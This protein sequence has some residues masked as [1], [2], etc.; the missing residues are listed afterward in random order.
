MPP[1][2]PPLPLHHQIIKVARDEDFRSRIGNDGRY[3]DLVDFSAIDV[4]YVPNSLTI[5]E[6][7]IP[8]RFNLSQG[9]L[10]EKFGTPVQC[11]HLWWWARRLNKTYRV[12]R[13][14]TTEEEKLSVCSKK[15]SFHFGL[16]S[17]VLSKKSEK[18][19]CS[20]LIPNHSGINEDDAL[21]TT[22]DIICY[23]KSL[24]QNWRIY[25]SVASFLQ[26]VCDH[27]EEEWKRHILEEEIAVLKRQADT[28]RLQKDESM[29]V[30]DQLKH[31]RDN[32]VRQ[33]NELCD[34]STP[35]IL[36]FSRKDLEQAIEHFKNTGDFGDTE[37]GHLYKGMIH[38]TIVAIKLSSSQSLFQQ[39]PGTCPPNLMA[40]L[41]YMDPEFNT[42]GELTTLSDVYSLGVIIL[43]LLTEMPPLTLSEKVAE[44]LESDSL[45]LLI[46][47]SAGD[48][49]YIQAKQLALIG[50]SCTEM[51]RKKRPDLLTKVWKVVEPL[52]R[53][54]LA[55]TWPYLQ[56]ATGDS[57]VPSAFICPI[58]LEIMKDPQMASDG[59]TYEAEA[60]RSWF[61]RGNIL[62][63][64]PYI[65]AKQL[66]LIGL[67]CTEMTR[68]KRPDLLTK[69]WKVVE[70]LTRKPLAATWPYLQSATGDSCVPSAFICPISLEI[71]KDPQM[72]SDGF[73]YEAE[74]IRSWF[75]RGNI[76]GLR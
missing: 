41:P 19:G 8:Y 46:D 43:Q 54:P 12:D 18:E 60:I 24:P 76:L 10:M 9:T 3:F 72:A 5:Y 55:A 26:H 58:S 73:T 22:G 11:Q 25:S 28:D 23:Q 68:K 34:Q 20:T 61:D 21:I 6:F 35:V 13:P 51:T 71:M 49:P 52:T 44:A 39:E 50:L 75:D 70:P 16:K 53:K 38:Y 36:N 47:K 74:A 4:F 2:P 57:C 69:V 17:A 30:C 63:D 27:K 42:T 32:A 31:E 65:Q 1:P 29:T 45:H 48:W 56:S 64:W 62:G 66:A 15:Y 33:V 7:K 14:L 40:R 37:Y 59:F 67:S